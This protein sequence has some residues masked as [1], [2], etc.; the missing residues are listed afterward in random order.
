[1]LNIKST[2]QHCHHFQMKSRSPNTAPQQLQK[3]LLQS[4][5][6][7]WTDEQIIT[8]FRN[9]L[10]REVIEW[11]DSLPALNLSQLVRTEIQARFEIDYFNSAKTARSKTGG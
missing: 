3:V 5:A 6:A 10:K 1:M 7:A 11:F 9:A 2:L 4:Q 8:H